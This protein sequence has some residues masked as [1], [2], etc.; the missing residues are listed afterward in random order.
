MTH[1]VSF[2]YFVLFF[3]RRMWKWD[4]ST[5]SDQ[6]LRCPHE[7]SLGPELPTEHTGKTLIRLG[8]C[9]GWSGIRLVHMPFCWFCHEVTQMRAPNQHKHWCTSMF[10]S[11][12]L[13]FLA[14]Y[15]H[16]PDIYCKSPKN[17]DTRKKYCNY[18]KILFKRCRGNG[19]QSD[20]GVHCLLSLKILEHY[21]K[22]FNF[23]H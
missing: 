14:S 6:S 4:T 16:E 19:K 23:Y 13:F 3:T 9:P 21:G 12:D 22:Y 17:S 1:R 11:I 2:S 8:V 15:H 10:S 5:Q 20:V 18:P 7:G